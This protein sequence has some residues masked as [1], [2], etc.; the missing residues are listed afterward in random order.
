[1]SLFKKI[2]ALCLV[3]Y[4]FWLV[5]AYGFH[6]IDWLNL[7]IHEGGHFLFTFFGEWLHFLGGTFAQI[8]VPLGIALYFLYRRQRYESAFCGFWFGESM[9]YM[10]GYMADAQTQ[11]LPLLGKGTHD[12]NWMF[13]RMGVLEHCEGIAMFF[14]VVASIIVLVSVGYMIYNAFR[15][16]PPV[17]SVISLTPPTQ[18]IKEA[19]ESKRDD[20]DTGR[21][22]WSV[23][24]QDDNGNVSLVK[25]GLTHIEAFSL[26][27]EYEAKGHKQTYWAQESQ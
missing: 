25:A 12:W 24:R 10:A 16:K 21:P 3:P 4:A 22:G 1:M 27:A 26:I 13:S 17:A 6:F 9:M 18:Q 20:G 19:N 2:F 23:W 15:K 14:H 7:F 5:F 8:L 11:A